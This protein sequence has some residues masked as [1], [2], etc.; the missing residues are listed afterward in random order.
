MIR[1]WQND[2]TT[3]NTMFRT[4]VWPVIARWCGDGRIIHIETMRNNVV[5]NSLDTH[6]GIDIWQIVDEKGARGIASRVQDGSF[7]KY[8][9]FTIRESRESGAL[10]EYRKREEALKSGRWVYPYLTCHA[11]ISDSK[12]LGV[13]LARTAD[14]MI[15]TKE[16]GKAWIQP[17][18][19]AT[20]WCIP[21][22]YVKPIKVWPEGLDLSKRKRK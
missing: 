7:F 3:S 6:C 10:T 16:P 15:I 18:H 21:W 5:A 14:V 2:L 11:Y 12:L 17:T 8:L 13:A 4:L 19:N 1:N 22:E 9:T 20:F